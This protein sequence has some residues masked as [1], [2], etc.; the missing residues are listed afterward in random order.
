MRTLR[1]LWCSKTIE[2]PTDAGLRPVTVNNN[3]MRRAINTEKNLL[4]SQ[5]VNSCLATKYKVK[6]QGLS[7]LLAANC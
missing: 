3:E 1:E 6:K 4:A 5:S 7:R 2:R